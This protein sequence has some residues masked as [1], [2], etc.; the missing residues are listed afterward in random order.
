MSTSPHDH[1]PRQ[2][3]GIEARGGQPSRVK[4]RGEGG[5]RVDFK[6]E[7]PNSIERKPWHPIIG[8]RDIA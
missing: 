5:I 6:A 7:R 3:H 1:R 2:H 4:G 8:K